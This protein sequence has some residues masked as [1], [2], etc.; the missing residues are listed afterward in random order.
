MANGKGNGNGGRVPPGRWGVGVACNEWH[1]VLN[2]LRNH[3]WQ[4]SHAKCSSWSSSSL[5]VLDLNIDCPLISWLPLPAAC[6]N[7]RKMSEINELIEFYGKI[8]GLKT[9]PT[10]RVLHFSLLSALLSLR[11]LARLLVEQFMISK[12]ILTKSAYGI[13]WVCLT[14][15]GNCVC[16]CTLYIYMFL[17]SQKRKGRGRKS[18]RAAV[19]RE[20]RG[21]SSCWPL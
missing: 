13:K 12:D 14:K 6:R 7:Y 15:S 18:M 10:I 17:S 2:C 16:V 19:A 11:F 3:K 8:L 5:L 1:Q 20:L 9:H 4:K 21:A